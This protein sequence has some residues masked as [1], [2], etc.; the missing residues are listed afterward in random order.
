MSEKASS[1]A[2]P[3]CDWAALASADRRYWADEFARGGAKTSLRASAAL[4]QHMRSVR[5]DWPTAAERDADLRH[6][7]ET[8]QLLARVARVTAR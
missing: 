2:L 7:V 8:Q 1:T 5:A 6:H 3:A 4:R